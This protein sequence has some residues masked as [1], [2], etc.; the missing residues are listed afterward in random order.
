MVT[1]LAKF[2]T[3]LVCNFVDSRKTVYNRDRLLV[4]IH[5]RFQNIFMHNN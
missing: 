3:L 1:V 5:I 4:F 2:Y